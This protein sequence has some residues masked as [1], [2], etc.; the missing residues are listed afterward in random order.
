LALELLAVWQV[1]KYHT[2]RAQ[3]GGSIPGKKGPARA[4]GE[5]VGH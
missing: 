1:G 3:F 2:V 5:E 4:S